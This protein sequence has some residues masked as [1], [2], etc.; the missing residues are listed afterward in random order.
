MHTPSRL[1]RK[2]RNIHRNTYTSKAWRYT[3]T[4]T[5]ETHVHRNIYTLEHL[6]ICAK[7]K[8]MHTNN[9]LAQCMYTRVTCT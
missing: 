3:D 8:Q 2:C 1:H 4:C 9:H 6:Y 7:K 5:P